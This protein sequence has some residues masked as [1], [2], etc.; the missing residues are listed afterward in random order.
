[1]APVRFEVQWHTEATIACK[2]ERCHL[3]YEKFRVD[4]DAGHKAQ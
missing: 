3:C 4:L 1:M 2:E